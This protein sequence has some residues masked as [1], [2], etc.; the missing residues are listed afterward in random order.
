MGKKNNIK[1]YQRDT[2]YYIFTLPDLATK[3]P[4]AGQTLLIQY[5]FFFTREKGGRRLVDFSL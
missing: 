2:C 4:L 1:K 3:Q 5:H